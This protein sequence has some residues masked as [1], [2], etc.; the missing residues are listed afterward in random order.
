MLL[1]PTCHVSCNLLLILI[2]PDYTMCGRFTLASDIDEFLERFGI[3][4]PLDLAHPR[5]YN[6]APSQPLLALVAD[7]SPRYEIMEWGFVPGWAK[8]ESDAKA[9]INA[10]VESL[11]EGKPYFKGAF[12]SARCAIV[13]DG[14]YEWKKMGRGAAGG[15]QPYRIG[16]NDG[17]LFAMAGLWSSPRT[18]D[19]GERATCAI[20]TVEPNELMAD[21][22]NR[23]PAILDP[24]DLDIWLDPK[25]AP[26]DLFAA[27]HPY[28][29]EK[30]RAYEVS[31]RVNSPANNGPDCILPLHE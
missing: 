15:K 2:E 23:M 17:A 4:I 5:Q 28:P 16:L 6:I 19:G 13:A 20:I 29:S 25:A 18:A 26:R 9:V 14:F 27:L 21:I 24:T 7:P 11:H 30:M 22:H 3:S 12:K 10:R 31:Q 8:P 1:F